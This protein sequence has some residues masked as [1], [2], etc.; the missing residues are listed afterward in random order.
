MAINLLLDDEQQLIVD[1]A[2]SFLAD[3]SPMTRVRTVSDSADG[4]D[5]ALWRGLADMGWCGVHLPEDVGGLGLGW[6]ELSL[7]H[8]QL[9][10]H[11]ACVPFFEGIALAATALREL[12]DSASAQ[13]LLPQLASGELRAALAM[14]PEAG[15]AVA[16]AHASPGGW[17][18][19][20]RWPQVGAAGSADILLL[21]SRSATGE[22]LLFAVG[23]DLP[24]LQV[25]AVT[26]VDA[27]RRSANVHAQALSLPESACLASGAA[28]VAALARV[29]CLAAIALAAEQV[30]VAQ[31]CL[32]LTL[33]YTAQRNQFGKAIAGFQA[34]KHRCSQMLVM[35]EA[36]RSAVYG[37]ACMADATTN[38]A[39]LLLYAAQ[40]RVEATEAAQFC[41]RESI[42][43]H[44]G[45]GFTWEYDPHFYLRRSQANSQRLGSVSVWLEQVAQQLLDHSAEELA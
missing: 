42:Q 36:A 37:A 32:D 9:G 22:W 10:R 23:K 5:H 21:P 24:G 26:T 20:G 45:V 19:E 2:I 14:P 43:L 7:L 27:T 6:I 4:I 15:A 30:G 11:L 39:T 29:R 28:L 31:Q 18:L 3:A 25:Q 38:T 13:T 34:V 44:G 35:V 12:P 8:E 17:L 40:A 33:A 16:L 41:A 1:S